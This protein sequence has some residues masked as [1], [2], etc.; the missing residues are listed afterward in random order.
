MSSNK[1]LRTVVTT[2][3]KNFPNNEYKKLKT[4]TT[5]KYFKPSNEKP[6]NTELCVKFGDAYIP[7]HL[8]KSSYSY[9]EF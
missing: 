4:V 2:Y 1:P 6:A 8:E 7:T 9:I 3:Y 5:K